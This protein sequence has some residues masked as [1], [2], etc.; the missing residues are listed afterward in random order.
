MPD[1]AP[2]QTSLDCIPCLC[3]ATVAAVRASTADPALQDSILGET[4]FHLAM[5]DPS[6][7]PAALAEDLRQLLAKRLG[8][9]AH[10]F[11]PDH[12]C[13]RS[14]NLAPSPPRHEN[15]HPAQ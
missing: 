3:R 9:P 7:P 12:H 14:L 13:P 5:R 11:A 15:R 6:L 8:H 1:N 2:A 10:D 4:L